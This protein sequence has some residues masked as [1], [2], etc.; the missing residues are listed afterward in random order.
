MVMHCSFIKQEQEHILLRVNCYSKF[1]KL[2]IAHVRKHLDEVIAMLDRPVLKVNFSENSF[3]NFRRNYSLE[4]LYAAAYD[5]NAKYS[6][7]NRF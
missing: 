6:V 2:K 4:R 5:G 7:R 1:G 3:R